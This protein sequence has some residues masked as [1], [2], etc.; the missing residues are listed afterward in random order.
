M[1]DV[2]SISLYR[3][4]GAKALIQPFSEADYVLFQHTS[5]QHVQRATKT[6]RDG[7]CRLK[8]Q[9]PTVWNDY[10]A[11]SVTSREILLD[12]VQVM[13][14]Q[15][16]QLLCC[17]DL[18]ITGCSAGTLFFQKIPD[19]SPAQ[20]ACLQLGHIDKVRVV[21]LSESEIEGLG[22]VLSTN[23]KY[24]VSVNNKYGIRG[25]KL[26]GNPW[27]NLETSNSRSIDALKL[28]IKM[29]EYMESNGW[30][31]VVSF[32]CSISDYDADSLLF[33]RESF[34]RQLPSQ[35]CAIALESKHKIRLIGAS[36]EVTMFEFQ[37]AVRNHWRRGV[38]E[39][40][41]FQGTLQIK[42]TGRPWTPNTTEENIASAQL[43]CGVLQKM[44]NL[45]WRWH[46]AI[47]MSVSVA[48]KST[49]FLSRSNR[50]DASDLG[51]GVIGCLQPKGRGK[52]NFVS[53]PAPILQRVVARVQGN[54][55]C[56][57]LLRI[58]QHGP[59]CATVHFQCDGLHRSCRTTEKTQTAKV[60]TDLIRIVGD[61][62]EDA[63]FLGSADISGNYTS[64]SENSSAYSLDT[65][66][67]F[68][69]FL[70]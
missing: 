45:G 17:A 39:T 46:C 62:S 23:W 16:M 57:P 1:V 59:S 33:F 10:H 20:L 47:D 38:S 54:R 13:Q 69:F 41:T 58:E 37:T 55:W 27:H 52:V 12:L 4:N 42:C 29:L 5:N 56:V 14:Q 51:D 8:F 2:Q 28:V 19:T 66:A 43:I 15:N 9:S 3:Y 48:D 60:Y 35:I 18:N 53:F 21:Q 44:W 6:P 26:T 65:D 7:G 36:D 68:F 32:D 34:D 70:S 24:G 67:F 63:I 61:S 25:Y 22:H 50:A 11:A 64:G 49:F 31:R 40:N 30:S